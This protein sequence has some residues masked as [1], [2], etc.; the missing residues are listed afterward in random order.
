MSVIAE[1]DFSGSDEIYNDKMLA[2]ACILI[3]EG[4]PITYWKDC[5]TNKLAEPG[6]PSGI[7]MPEQHS[8]ISAMIRK[9]ET[10]RLIKKHHKHWTGK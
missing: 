4:C 2:Y 7:E 5:F 9:P 8:R 3:H 6:Q 10:I 1:S